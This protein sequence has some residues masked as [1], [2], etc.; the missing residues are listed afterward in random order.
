MLEDGCCGP[1]FTFRPA[2]GPRK[3]LDDKSAA[4]IVRHLRRHGWAKTPPL[5]PSPLCE[6]IKKDALS[7]ARQKEWAGQT[8]RTTINSP[9][10]LKEDSWWDL[11]LWA[12]DEEGPLAKI[13]DLCYGDC[14]FFDVAGG[15]VVAPGATFRPA[16]CRPHSDYSGVP[17]G[18]CVVSFF[19]HRWQAGHEARA[20]ELRA[21]L[22]IYSRDDNREHICEG[23]PG[24]LLLRDADTIHHGSCNLTHETRI[25]PALRFILPGALRAGYMPKPSLPH[26]S[27]AYWKGRALSADPALAA[28]LEKKLVFLFKA[29]A[30][31]A[32]PFDRRFATTSSMEHSVRPPATPERASSAEY[33]VESSE[34]GAN[35][36]VVV[37]TSLSMSEGSVSAT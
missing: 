26:P 14:W 24:E 4:D 16:P 17:G 25:L 13:L 22:V 32:R 35:A 2:R 28:R 33:E 9:A 15:D 6:A 29:P 36:S 11:L 7:A 30:E 19:V 8:E 12:L 21:P 1:L 27:D 23:E 18:I 5:V 10:N 3:G 34:R 37:T 20:G 31:A